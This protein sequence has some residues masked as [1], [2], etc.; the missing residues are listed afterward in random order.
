MTASCDVIGNRDI[1]HMTSHIVR[2]VTHPEEVKE[3]MHKLAGVTFVQSVES[4]ALAMVTPLLVRGLQSG[5]TA[6]MRQS[7]V[8]IDNMSKLVDDPIDAAPFMPLLMP[9]LEKATETISDPEAR[10]VAERSLAQ[11]QRLNVLVEKEKLRQKYIDHK[12]VVEAIASKMKAKDADIQINHIAHLCCSN[13]LQS[14][15]TTIARH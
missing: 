9:A 1:E 15:T 4:P 13:A 3:I 14:T 6:T 2:S 12:L 10:S 7:A 8:I 11:L 5:V